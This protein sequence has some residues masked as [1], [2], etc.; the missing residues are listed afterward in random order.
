ML[1][2]SHW[3]NKHKKPKKT[4]TEKTNKNLLGKKPGGTNLHENATKSSFTALR[5][6]CRKV[7]LLVKVP[8][9]WEAEPGGVVGETILG[10]FLPPLLP[11]PP[12]RTP[13][14]SV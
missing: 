5:R 1:I 11:A 14:K 10:L 3:Q 6:F 9:V 12:P 13:T 4:K 2:L 7:L 8:L